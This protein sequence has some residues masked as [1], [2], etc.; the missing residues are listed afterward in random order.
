M[1][2]GVETMLSLLRFIDEDL[3]NGGG[4]N[5]ENSTQWKNNE[6]LLDKAKNYCSIIMYHYNSAWNPIET[7]SYLY[8]AISA[9]YKTLF[10][11]KYQSWT[12][13]G[14]ENELRTVIDQFTTE[15]EADNFLNTYG[16]FWYFCK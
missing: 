7:K 16:R 5:I 2:C 14:F 12:G 3:T 15:S 9:G 13:D 8:A 10:S 6:V 11:F 1:N 4:Y